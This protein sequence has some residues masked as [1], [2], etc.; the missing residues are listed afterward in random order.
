MLDRLNWLWRL[1]ATALSFVCFGVGGVLLWVLVFPVLSLLVRDRQR[2][3]VLARTIIHQAFRAFIELMRVLGILTYEVHGLDKLDR[4]GLLILANHP[5]LIDVVFLISFTR[6]ADC[7]V[8]AAL[9]RNPFT[10]GAVLA[11]GFICNDTGPGMVEDSIAS[12]RAGNNLIIFPEGTR[13]PINGDAAKLQRGAANVAVRGGINVTPV[14]IQCQPIMLPK[15][16]P[17]WQIPHRR[18]HFRIEVCDDLPVAVPA[19]T[20]T[21][22][23]QAARRLTQQLTDYFAMETRREH[24][25]ASA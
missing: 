24:R 15:G 10:R 2:L 13:T 4:H 17:W 5:S 8:K 19:H 22:E 25:H 3:S 16:V 20:G 23:A 9:V 6:H 7:V 12:L 14:L 21:S 1:F 18:P 11:A